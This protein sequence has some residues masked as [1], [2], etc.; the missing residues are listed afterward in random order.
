M[1]VTSA[2]RLAW[3]RYALNQDCI[4]AGGLRFWPARQGK[5]YK[6]DSANRTLI[7]AICESWHL[8]ASISA[9]V[10]YINQIDTPASRRPVRAAST[11]SI[12]RPLPPTAE[13]VL[14]RASICAHP[15][16][17]GPSFCPFNLCAEAGALC[18]LSCIR[19]DVGDCM[20]G[21]CTFVATTDERQVTG[22]FP[23]VRARR[24]AARVTS[25]R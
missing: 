18:R 24:A 6:I 12:P 25:A 7:G 1:E 16:Q 5:W 9:W 11:A 21:Q 2:D 19:F 23:G 15:S 22:C 14:H 17:P 20:R 10:F 3:H 13:T 4:F 8:I